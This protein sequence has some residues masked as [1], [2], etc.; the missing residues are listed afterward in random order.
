[1]L[2]SFPDAE[3]GEA[4]NR[5][6]PCGVQKTMA[7]WRHAGD[8]N[9]PRASPLAASSIP[10][11]NPSNCALR[12][13]L[14]RRADSNCPTPRTPSVWLIAIAFSKTS[15]DSFGRTMQ[16]AGGAYSFFVAIK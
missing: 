15:T 1:M 12:G 6:Y 11:Q 14:L 8:T 16:K 3:G 2:L 7:F 5:Q 10:V 9:V 13:F 4:A